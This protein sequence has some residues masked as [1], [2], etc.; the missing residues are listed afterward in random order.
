MSEGTLI[1]TLFSIVM[2]TDLVASGGSCQ[3]DG[4]TTPVNRRSSARERTP[5]TF[6]QAGCATADNRVRREALDEVRALF[7][8]VC[9]DRVNPRAAEQ[10]GRLAR[11]RKPI[12]QA[13]KDLWGEFS[14]GAEAM[15][16]AMHNF[17]DSP[18]SS[19]HMV[20]FDACK[21]RTSRR[22]GVALNKLL[23]LE[24]GFIERIRYAG[25]KGSQPSSDGEDRRSKAYKVDIAL[26][27][28]EYK[29]ALNIIEGKAP[30][31]TIDA[32]V[33]D[34]L[35]SKYPCDACVTLP[36]P[37]RGKLVVPEWGDFRKVVRCKKVTKHGVSGLTFGEL[38]TISK[39]AILEENFLG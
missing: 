13:Y 7:P 24:P 35:R 6:Y 5:T 9:D 38:K 11:S 32:R 34:L 3:G 23:T 39:D 26:E 31:R 22:V 37:T 28:F 18:K 21:D 33:M 29:K 14:D 20:K 16:I 19:A 17:V 15:K 2:D 12:D 25:L 1:K 36:A 30:V 4:S 27:K 10:A 8:Q